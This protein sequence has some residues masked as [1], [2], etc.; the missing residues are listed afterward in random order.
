MPKASWDSSD[1]GNSV[2]DDELEDY[3]VYDGDLPPKG[4]YRFLLR[5]LQLST[6]KN[7]DPMLKGLMVIDEPAGSKKAQ[8]NG[9]DVWFNLNVTR[10]GAPWVNNFLGAVVP[11]NKVAAIRKAFWDQKVMV[12]K[13]EPPTI[14]SIGAVKITEGMLVSAQCGHKMYNGDTD[15]DAK[16]FFRPSNT[17]PSG[18]ADESTADDVEDDWDDSEEET[19]KDAADDEA[20]DDEEY[21]ARVDEL[22][23]MDRS[24]LLKAAKAAKVSVKR[25]T[26]EDKIIDAILAAEF[27]EEEEDE[28]PE[29]EEL[30]DEEEEEPEP[31]PE[32]EPAPKARRTRAKP[33]TAEPEPAARARTGSRR[34]R[35]PNEPPF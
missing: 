10:Q 11:E 29:E 17:D 32:P 25:G 7:N 12:D 15:L 27:P 5:R 20:D 23:A 19:E 21:N 24:G 1:L 14:L 30:E 26:E 16:R 13:S 28:E 34:R 35:A 6:N 9:K 22:E 8:F 33:A 18:A 2:W 31:E 3:P 4:V